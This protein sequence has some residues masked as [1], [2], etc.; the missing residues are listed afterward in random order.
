MWGKRQQ[1]R[2]QQARHLQ[3]QDCH[4]RVLL[5]ALS[6]YAPALEVGKRVSYGQTYKAV[7]TYQ[8][9]FAGSDLLVAS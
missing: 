9:F 4:R 3:E 5:L 1:R 8:A 7:V 6:I 2:D